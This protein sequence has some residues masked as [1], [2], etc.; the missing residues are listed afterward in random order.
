MHLFPPPCWNGRAWLLLGPCL[1]CLGAAQFAKTDGSFDPKAAERLKRGIQ[2]GF[3]G[4]LGDHLVSPRGLMSGLICHL[5]CV[6]GIVTKCSLVQPKVVRSVHWCE[7]TQ[8]YSDRQYR[9]ATA[10]DLGV[11]VPNGGGSARTLGQTAST[12]PTQDD[13]GN[14]LET[15]FGLSV[16]KNH[17]VVTVQEMPE[18]AP[19]GQLPRS[20]D[21]VLDYDLVDRVKP[22]DRVQAVGVYRAMG[23][24]QGASTNGVFGTK[25]LG[26]SL[27]VLGQDIGGVVLTPADVATI[28]ELGAR[29][30]VLEVLGASFAPSVYGQEHVK[31]ALVL[32]LIG[33]TEKNLPNGTH[34]RGD[35]NVLMVGDPS[36]AK[37]QLLRAAMGIA[38]LAVSTT[39]RGS[40]GVGLTAAVTSDPETGERKLEAGAMVLADRGVVCI[41]EFDK[42]SDA[43]RVAIHEVMEQ[44]TVTVAKAGIHA[45]LNARCSVLAAANP[46]Y[47]QY[48]KERRPQENIGLPDSL[49]SRFDLL[50]VV[51]DQMDPETDRKISHHVLAGHSYRKPGTDMEPE[52]LSSGMWDAAQASAGGAAEPGEQT[53]V[54]NKLQPV[55]Y[56]G[57]GA[58]GKRRKTG[59][60]AGAEAGDGAVL[61]KAFLKKYLHYAKRLAPVLTDEARE[62][63][64]TEYAGLRAKA[65]ET[66]RTL[67]VTARQLETLIRLSTAHA[68]AR[69][70]DKV[71]ESDAA[72]AAALLQFALYHESGEAAAA[73]SRPVD[74]EG[75]DEN[76]DPRSGEDE[77]VGAKRPRSA[78]ASEAAAAAGASV[79]PEGS[80]EDAMAVDE[81]AL[82]AGGAR[83]AAFEAAVQAAMGEAEEMEI[84]TLLPLVNGGAA[85]GAVSEAEAEV[86]LKH[87]ED[88]NLIMVSDTTVFRI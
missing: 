43:D 13:A 36:T 40:S 35:L 31:R 54:W 79:E 50:F 84:G 51:L 88:A 27:D 78:R 25:V 30:D 75:A 18:R 69:L 48:N 72:A 83:Y 62:Y 23:G 6:E 58:R 38:P 57:S 34:L 14:P 41:D 81:A 73:P 39:G 47:G 8:Q 66:N 49:L 2:I 68:K 45:S 44:Q 56:G 12:Y 22:G 85:A 17:Q 46:V 52:P 1:V 74:D 11:E 53:P 5:V 64:A 55:L 59:G 67:P 42:M 15:E 65:A 29:P 26:N 70:S 20:V 61:S 82:A 10:L 87:M 77:G 21:V 71:E 24:A 86:L 16:Y 19:L 32:Q 60:A 76:A 63:I 4:S 3:G 28:K 33:G 37:S 7:A 9:D 80:A